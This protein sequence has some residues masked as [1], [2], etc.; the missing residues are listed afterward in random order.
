M[1][2]LQFYPKV[3]EIYIC[4]FPKEYVLQGEM[5]KDRPVIVL[6][7][8]LEGRN[9]LVSIVPIS[10]TPPQPSYDWHVIVSESCLPPT[11]WP[12]D[13]ERWAE[14]DMVYTVFFDRLNKVKSPRAAEQQTWQTGS[15]DPT[16]SRPTRAA[17]SIAICWAKSS[18]H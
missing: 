14:C 7:R 18:Q 4:D 3:G 8:K 12:K 2:G 17:L 1:M 16:S 6:S 9:G 11:L 5:T 13:G 15:G 10:M